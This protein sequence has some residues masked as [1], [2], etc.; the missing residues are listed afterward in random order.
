M[1][2]RL[3]PL[4]L[5]FLV[6]GCSSPEPEASPPPSVTLVTD[7][8]QGRADPTMGEHLHDYWGSSDRKL[9]L[10]QV[11]PVGYLTVGGDGV[12]AIALPEPG[13]VVPQGAASVEIT[14]DWTPSPEFGAL[15][16]M[17]GARLLV[18]TAADREAQEV[19]PVTEG[20]TVVFPSTNERNDLPHQ[21]LSA[22]EFHWA[23]DPVTLPNGQQVTS[24]QGELAIKVEAVRGLEIPLYP[25]H[26]DQWL[27][28]TEMPL[29]SVEGTAVMDGDPRSGD[30]RCYGACPP[31][32]VPGDG[33]V[34]PIDAHHVRV[35]LDRD[36]ASPTRFGLAYHTAVSRDWVV[37]QPLEETDVSRVYVIDV[38]DGGD[39]A[40]A[41][42][43]AW[44]F[45]L[46]VEEPVENGYIVDTY[47]VSATVHK[48]P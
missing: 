25:G 38:L 11:H 27:G 3:A 13:D 24:Y 47:R 32:L 21:V 35:T 19:G 29:F 44:E 34:V 15:N 10:E 42:Q 48:D 30:M 45:A 17:T 9:V 39:G 16:Q 26:P 33:V 6:A 4:V 1:L 8:S 37:A 36:M 43:S 14:L 31:R 40:Y 28:R 41:K 20:Q 2:R 22:W 7:P 12:A 5:A 18:R 46:F 23:L